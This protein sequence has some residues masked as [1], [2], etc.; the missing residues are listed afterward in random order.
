MWEMPRNLDRKVK[1]A[2]ADTIKVTEDGLE[3]TANGRPTVVQL[4]QDQSAE[5]IDQFY[6][7]ARD[8][9][10]QGIYKYTFPSKLAPLLFFYNTPRIKFIY[11]T[12][13]MSLM[14]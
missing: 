5:N 10:Y 4:T 7:T 12:V 11:H 3:L 1:N 6:P 9:F 2:K 13:R 8:I 14:I